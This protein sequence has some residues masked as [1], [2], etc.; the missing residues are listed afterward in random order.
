MK[1][2]TALKLQDKLK[3]EI[4]GLQGMVSQLSNPEAG[5]TP[6][7]LKSGMVI[8]ARSLVRLNQIVLEVTAAEAEPPPPVFPFGNLFGK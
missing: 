3:R 1:P 8:L 7:G 6:G 4:S 5:I 2:E